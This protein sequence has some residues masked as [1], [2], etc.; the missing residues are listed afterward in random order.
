[1]GMDVGMGYQ[2][3]IKADLPIGHG[4]YPICGFQEEVQ[5]VGDKDT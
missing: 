1:M 2:G 5:I 3:L 4:I